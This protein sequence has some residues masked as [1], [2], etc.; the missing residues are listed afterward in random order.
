MKYVKRMVI[1][2]YEVFRWDGK[3]SKKLD[4]FFGE[5]THKISSFDGCIVTKEGG[6]IEPNAVILKDVD[7]CAGKEIV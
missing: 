3:P 2:E 5:Q 1:E 7:G 4:A 6:L